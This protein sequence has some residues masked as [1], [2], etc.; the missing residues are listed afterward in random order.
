[1]IQINNCPVCGQ[2]K[3]SHYLTC[4][5]YTVSGT[6]FNISNCDS[7]GFK[8][9]NPIPEPQNLGSYY[10]SEDYISHSDTN[11]G[12]VSKLYKVVRSY[13]IG[14]KIK[15]I[16]KLVSRGT[17]LDYGC[18]TG[19]FLSACKNDGWKAIGIEPDSGARNIA[20]KS[21]SELYD[22]KESLVKENNSASFNMITLWHVLEHVVDL[23][24]TLKILT[25]KLEQDGVMIIAVPNYKS[26]DAQHYQEFWA[27][28]DV[29]R[30][31]YHFDKKSITKLMSLHG[32][33]L[34][35]TLPMLFD[36]F[37]VSLLSEKYKS[38]KSNLIKA[39]S[40]GLISN[41]K[42]LF[43]RE[44]SSHIYIFKRAKKG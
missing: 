29:P 21:L 27:A 34:Q 40:I 39:F 3:S 9:T 17:I 43:S 4:K 24:E 11:K 13:T 19:A 31:L 6:S 37:Y 33:E 36:S 35:N 38:G 42:A 14:K 32:F 28:Y 23:Q 8:Y 2:S 26:Y 22:S 41:L 10:K 25:N 12:L 18:G 30:H 15:L 1:M 7:C 20:G 16:N 5:D 44:C